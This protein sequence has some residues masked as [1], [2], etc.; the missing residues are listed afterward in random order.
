M[1]HPILDAVKQTDKQWIVDLLY[2][3][4]SGDIAKFE[5][6]ASLLQQQVCI[7]SFYVEPRV[8][9]RLIM[10]RYQWKNLK[11]FAG[12]SEIKSEGKWFKSDRCH[13]SISCT[14]FIIVNSLVLVYWSVTSGSDQ[15]LHSCIELSS[16][17]YVL[18]EK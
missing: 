15:I 9:F 4:N 6:S 13:R 7:Y 8:E 2:A 12:G 5:K 16:L 14:K 3:F 18:L 11:V 17:R 10:Y 1:A